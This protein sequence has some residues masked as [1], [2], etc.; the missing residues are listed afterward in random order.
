[1]GYFED[2]FTS[3]RYRYECPSC[4]RRASASDSPGRCPDCGTG[5]RNIAVP[6]E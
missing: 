3:D 1:M 4:G 6:R 5:V 2:P